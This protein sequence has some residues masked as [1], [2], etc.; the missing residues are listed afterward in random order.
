MVGVGVSMVW[1]SSRLRLNLAGVGG[2]SFSLETDMERCFGISGFSM[3]LTQSAYRR[4]F[5]VSLMSSAEGLMQAI[6]AVVPLPVRQSRRTCKSNLMN[7][8]VT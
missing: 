1:F 7:V 6:M 4:V 8:T 3:L 2:S 5:E